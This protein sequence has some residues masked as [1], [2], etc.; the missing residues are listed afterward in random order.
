[1]AELMSGGRRARPDRS[2]SQACSRCIESCLKSPLVRPGARTLGLSLSFDSMRIELVGWRDQLFP[3][4][5]KVMGAPAATWR[6]SVQGGSRPP[7]PPLLRWCVG[8]SRSVVRVLAHRRSATAERSSGLVSADPAVSASV[9]MRCA[10]VG[11]AWRRP[12]ADHAA[13]AE[14]TGQHSGLLRHH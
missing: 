6:G 9:C 14:H 1:M 4:S 8:G 5:V 2:D 13:S 7:A 10:D 11:V 12:R 3:V